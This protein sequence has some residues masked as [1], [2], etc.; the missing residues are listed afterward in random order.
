MN[1]Y[2]QQKTKRI[3]AK[4]RD[5]QQQMTQA[6]QGEGGL[7]GQVQ[8]ELQKLESTL[9]GLE[10]SREKQERRI[11][12]GDRKSRAGLTSG[13]GLHLLLVGENVCFCL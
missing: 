3:S 12:V 11:Q 10:R 5:V 8:E 1:K 7:P 9:D 2:F 13:H 4:K 6:Q